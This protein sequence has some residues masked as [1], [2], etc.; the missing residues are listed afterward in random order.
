MRFN[1][2]F[3]TDRIRAD[4]A[5]DPTTLVDGIETLKVGD[6]VLYWSATLRTLTRTAMVKLSSR[7]VYREMTVRSLRTTLRLF[8]LMR[9]H[10]SG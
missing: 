4:G 7:P 3:L 5:V 6:H 8:D 2:L 10:A 9:E 1:V